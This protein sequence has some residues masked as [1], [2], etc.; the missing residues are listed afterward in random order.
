[1]I[2]DHVNKTKYK[3]LDIQCKSKVKCGYKARTVMHLTVE[4]CNWTFYLNQW[5]GNGRS[6]RQLQE[7]HYL[8]LV[9]L[10]Q[11]Y[12]DPQCRNL[13]RA[14]KSIYQPRHEPINRRTVIMRRK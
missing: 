12:Y 10:G 7:A 6:L 2:I 1:M 4:N 3:R 5:K 8:S 11:H 9:L 14:R 13:L